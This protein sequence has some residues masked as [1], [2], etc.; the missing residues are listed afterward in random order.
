[1]KKIY[2]LIPGQGG[3]PARLY[4]DGEITAGE[5]EY[6]WWTGAQSRGAQRFRK[7]LEELGDV[8]VYINSPGGD[9]FAGA[10]MY[11]LLKSHSGHVRVLIMGIAA[12]A[13]SVVAMAGDEVLI[14][15]AGYMMIH[16]PW[17]IV[18]GNARDMEKEAQVLREIGEGILNAYLEKTGLPTDELRAMLT[19]ETYMNAQAA[20]EKGFAD[21]L[22]L[23]AEKSAAAS[24]TAPAATMRGQSYAPAAYM[25]RMRTL[26]GPTGQLPQGGSQD[27]Q[28]QAEAM[29]EKAQALAQVIDA[30]NSIGN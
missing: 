21:G 2:N 23:D 4:I 10:A 18:A 30:L 14:S 17:A 28:P 25:A 9:V 11:S 24:T 5:D 20:I 3:Q 1:M 15:P 22:W 26:S 8:D 16:D 27:S 12:S 19:E 29:R 6:D 7:D 13:A